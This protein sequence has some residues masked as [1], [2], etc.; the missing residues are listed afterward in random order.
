[1]EWSQLLMGLVSVGAGKRA[2]AKGKNRRG[3]RLE[4][5]EAD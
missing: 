4:K 5:E 1:M 3:K 2:E